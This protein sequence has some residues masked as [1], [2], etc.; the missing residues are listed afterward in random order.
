MAI[1]IIMD[2]KPMTAKPADRTSLGPPFDYVREPRAIYDASFAAIA[3]AADLSFLPGDMAGVAARMV[4]ACG[5][6]EIISSLVFS[7]GAGRAGRAAL[8]AG[9][10]IFVDAEMVASGIIRARLSAGNAVICTLNDPGVYEEARRREI[11][12]AHV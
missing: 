6:P 7:N 1:T 5:L 9:A 10:P 2:M 4:H 3:R 11:G 12:R 8:G